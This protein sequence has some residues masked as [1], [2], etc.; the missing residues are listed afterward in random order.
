MNPG[1]LSAI[2]HNRDRQSH[3]WVDSGIIIE[4]L[5]NESIKQ[6]I[7]VSFNANIG[8]CFIYST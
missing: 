8:L 5:D 6:F 4:E 1:I 3:S 7:K 2:P